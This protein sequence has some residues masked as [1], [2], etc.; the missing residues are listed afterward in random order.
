MLGVGLWCAD[1]GISVRVGLGCVGLG[2]WAWGGWVVGGGLGWVGRHN[3]LAHCRPHTH[4]PHTCVHCRDAKAPNRS[5]RRAAEQ[6]T[7][8]HAKQ[9]KRR[10]LHDEYCRSQRQARHERCASTEFELSEPN[11]Y[12]EYTDYERYRESQRQYTAAREERRQERIS[13]RSD[14]IYER[15]ERENAE[16]LVWQQNRLDKET[17]KA[18][19]Y[20]GLDEDE[21]MKMTEDDTNFLGQ[22][23]TRME[24]LGY[25]GRHTRLAFRGPG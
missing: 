4:T 11:R 21:R 22:I 20:Y 23:Q 7:H 12:H 16:R 25:N 24:N 14:Y 3:T 15:R 9:A 19:Q 17:S 2:G 18:R 5:Q 8:E 1:L 10:R 6:A 13:Q